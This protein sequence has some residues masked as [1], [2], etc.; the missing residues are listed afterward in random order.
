MGQHASQPAAPAPL[1]IKIVCLSD[2]HDQHRDLE[3]PAGDLLVHAGDFTKFGSDPAD[4]FAWLAAL[5]HKHKILVNGN[6]E[7]NAPWKQETARLA[8]EAGVIFLRD[9][10]VTLELNGRPVRVWGTEFMWAIDLSS[11]SSPYDAIPA[12]TDI[13]VSH[14]PAKGYCDEGAGCETMLKHVHRVRPRLFICGHM[15]GGHGIAH[16]TGDEEGTLF[17]NAA[18]AGHG[19]TLKWNATVLDV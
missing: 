12:G 13:I 19:H 9:E 2:T 10:A 1:G 11:P 5:P 6:H 15:H 8:K 3:V 16:G 17:V 4:F 14:G 7:K 18:N